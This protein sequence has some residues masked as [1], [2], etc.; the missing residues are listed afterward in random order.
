MEEQ[1]T[2]N[3]I[4]LLE[5]QLPDSSDECKV[6]FQNAVSFYEK[7]DFQQASSLFKQITETYPEKVEAYINY[8]DC[9]F[10]LSNQ[11]EAVKYWNL[12][13]EK[14][15]F[16]MNP[17]V[18]LGNYYLS[19][20]DLNKAKDEFEQA[21][22]I[23][24]YNE[25]LIVNLGITNEKMGSRKMAFMLYEFFMNNSFNVSSSLYR[26]V[27]KKVSMHKLNAISHM[28][29]GVF[30]ETKHFYR[31]A[32]QSFYESLRV[33]PNFSKTYANIGNIFFK[34]EK[35]DFAFLYWL[36]AY[37]IEKKKPRLCLNLALCAEKLDK[38]IDAYCFYSY[39]IQITSG[40]KEI[41]TARKK[42][43]HLKN[44]LSQ[45]HE[46]VKEY[47]TKI[48]EYI[49]KK[50]FDT[51]IVMYENLYFLTK[52]NEFYKKLNELQS[53]TNI[54]NRAAKKTIE[55]ANFC[56]KQKNYDKAV[57]KAKIARRLWDNAEIEMAAS[58]I[59]NYAQNQLNLNLDNLVKQRML[60]EEQRLKE[61][62]EHKKHKR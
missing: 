12:A 33:F 40:G 7:R 32:L 44:E 53:T 36:E 52:N 8:A 38:K 60:E 21:F 43:Q 31:K 57:E 16:L 25:N 3:E 24:P 49:D 35:Y 55:Y 39:F 27:H 22:C 34:F 19:Q 15:P 23:D 9:Q 5:E 11:E 14:N 20:D 2:K 59:M 1:D 62:Q 46:F 41:L 26:N 10:E 45:D 30:F 37:K 4:V 58:D 28:K 6:L 29:L 54:I 47:K 17:Y 61:E 13:K 48:Q 50:E 56:N 42:A 51:A 18:N